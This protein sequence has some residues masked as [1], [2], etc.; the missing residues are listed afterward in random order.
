[1]TQV[2]ITKLD[3]VDILF[4]NRFDDS[5]VRNIRTLYFRRIFVRAAFVRVSRT[6]MERDKRRHGQL[7]R[8]SHTVLW[9]RLL[10]GFRLAHRPTIDESV[11]RSGPRLA[12]VGPTRPTFI[13][14]LPPVI[15]GAGEATVSGVVVTSCARR[16]RR[17]RTVFRCT[18]FSVEKTLGFSV[19]ASLDHLHPTDRPPIIRI[20]RGCRWRPPC[21]PLSRRLVLAVIHRRLTPIPAH[22]R[23]QRNSKWIRIERNAV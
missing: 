5:V 12:W 13:H 23:L 7:A 4:C 15:R 1:M 19:A 9:P 18:G 6:A 3:S 16:Y 8:R 14:R 11:F 21:R 20:R 17:G 22:G 2:H 10:S